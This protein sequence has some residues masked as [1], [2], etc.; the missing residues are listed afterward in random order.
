MSNSTKSN[1]TYLSL[2]SWY[3]KFGS[4]PY[5]EGIFLSFLPIGI[6]GI[7]LNILSLKIL[8][9]KEF[10]HAFYSYL[11]VYIINSIFLCY[12]TGTRFANVTRSIFGF[13]N[14]Y[15]A[16]WYI[17]YIAIPLNNI[18]FHYGSFIDIIIAFERVVTLSNKMNCFKRMKPLLVVGLFLIASILIDFVLY[19][20]FE[21]TEKKVMLNKTVSFIIHSY[22]P[23]PSLKLTRDILSYIFDIIPLLIE[24]SL[25]IWGIILVKSFVTKKKRVMTSATTKIGDRTTRLIGQNMNDIN[26]NV[27]AVA[28]TNDG[29]EKAKKMEMRITI[30]TIILTFFSIL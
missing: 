10:E 25:S 21:I 12:S 27:A 3:S 9:S 7:F 30:M 24:V 6:I 20:S 13:S 28:S 23:I 14:T 22:A 5:Q 17:I 26:S 2:T 19:F 16:N 15:S 8:N 4:A 29:I 11:R 1:V 18:C